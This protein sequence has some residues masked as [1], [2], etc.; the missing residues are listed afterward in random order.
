MVREKAHAKINLFLDILGKRLDNYHDLEMIMVSLKLHDTLSFSKRSDEKVVL[1]SEK[2]ITENVEDNL[3][4]KVVRHLLDAYLIET[5]VDV[6]IEKNIPI[7]AGLAGGS[8]DA[9]ASLRGMNRLFNLELSLDQLAD[10]GVTFG[11]DIPFCVHN[12][13]CIARGKG[14]E[15]LFLKRNLK[16]PVL[17]V[18]PPIEVSTKQVYDL[19][20]M[21][22]V[23]NVK[24]TTMTNAIYNKNYELL[25]RNLHNALEPFSFELFPEI[26]QLKE[27]L[28]TEGADA[29]L[30][31]GS[32]PTLVVFDK[33]AHLL[34]ELAD[35]YRDTNTVHLTKTL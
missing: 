23:K 20:D 7:A 28:K 25:V 29:V 24:I 12:R 8:A 3:V 31:S 1:H 32:G 9:A 33:N 5:G 11:A 2:P 13:L 21:D 6:H 18:T 26:R 22:K 30:M 16:M 14:E 19:V 17:L 27:S 34:K 4:Y 10:I 15:L 35:K